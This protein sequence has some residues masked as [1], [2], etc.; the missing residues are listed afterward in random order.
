MTVW[1]LLY[2]L[3]HRRSS[4]EY[5]HHI[6]IA[7]GMYLFGWLTGL[8]ALGMYCGTAGLA[9]TGIVSAVELAL[10]VI[11]VVQVAYYLMYREC[12]GTSTMVA[13]QET[14]H[15]VTFEYIQSLPIMAVVA[16]IVALIASG[17][18]IVIANLCPMMSAAPSLWQT[19]AA[20]GVVIFSTIYIWKPRH[21]L[22]IRNGIVALFLTVKKYRDTNKLYRQQMSERIKDLN[23][24]RLQPMD[25]PHTIMMV[26]GESA[27]R[28]YMSAFRPQ[29]R[30]TTP[31]LSA[32]AADPQFILF[33]NAY[34]C[35][36]HTVSTLE[37]ALTEFNQYNDRQFYNSC[38]IIDIARQAGYVTHW[39][40]NQ[41]HLGEADTPITLVAETADH[42]EWTRQ[43]FSRPQ[44]DETLID[45][46]DRVDPAQRNF[47][48]LHLKGNHFNYLNRYPKG[49]RP[50]GDI[51]TH[52]PVATYQCSLHYTDHI[53]RRFF[54]Y[55]RARLTLQ[56]R[57]Y[58]SDH[59]ERPDRRRTLQFGDFAMVRIPMFAFFANEYIAAHTDRWQALQAHRDSCFTNDLAYELLCGIF[60]IRSEHFDERN[61]LA[62]PRWKHTRE[63]LRTNE[64]RTPLTDEI[65]L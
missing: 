18:A 63:T 16:T 42:T 30:E 54:E 24:T 41:G 10:W 5:D 27:A 38:S 22:W 39:Y 49:Y 62:S 58:F 51:D 35:G 9:L 57:L 17:G 59:A 60:D 11:V 12:L 19:V 6:D 4:P 8:K 31:W 65:I 50:F 2:H 33:P 61:C 48:V 20:A 15:G 23:V 34:A 32:C 29:Q 7:F 52:D 36:T 26:I 47:V 55:G 64:G 14:N 25:A 43:E 53:L 21:G 44:Y 40:S 46:L 56:A 1:P 13:I 45:F 37:R 28:D 3:T